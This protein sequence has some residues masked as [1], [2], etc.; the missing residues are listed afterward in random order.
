MS[1]ILEKGLD[2][3][4]IEADREGVRYAVRSGYQ[5]VALIDLLKAYR[6]TKKKLNLKTLGKLTYL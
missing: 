4:G 1:V 2:K 6:R 3:K 5:P